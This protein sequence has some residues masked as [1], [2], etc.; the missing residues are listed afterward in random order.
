M[1]AAGDKPTVPA[2]EAESEDGPNKWGYDLYPERRGEQSKPKW[3]QTAFF[4]DG[5][6]LVE[7][8]HCERSV[9]NCF[10]NSEHCFL[11]RS[12]GVFGLE[13]VVDVR[14]TASSIFSSQLGI[15]CRNI[16]ACRSAGPADV[17]GPQSLRMV[18]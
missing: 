4:G 14:R 1:A 15:N 2:A 5:A 11:C 16:V 13:S 17:P 9:Y 3:W 8:T 18:T 10:L 12:R 6:S 7:K